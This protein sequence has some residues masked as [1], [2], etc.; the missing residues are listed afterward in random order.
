MQAEAIPLDS[1]V[2]IEISGAF[3]ARLHQFFYSVASSKSPEEFAKALE[4]IKSGKT[5][6]DAWAYH[7]ETLINLLKEVEDQ[8]KI[9]GKIKMIDVPDQPSSMLS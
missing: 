5:S 6:D 2:S 1:T 3:Y 7:L 8:A 9:Q 4:K